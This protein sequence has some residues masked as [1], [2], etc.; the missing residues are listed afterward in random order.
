[1]MN[2]SYIPSVAITEFLDNARHLEAEGLYRTADEHD[3]CGVG[4]I[5]AIDGK[6]R[7]QVVEAAISALKALHARCGKGAAYQGIFA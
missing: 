7:R 3:A 6:P 2:K 1:M 5:A 4:L